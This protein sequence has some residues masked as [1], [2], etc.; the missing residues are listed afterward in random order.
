MYI[1]VIYWSGLILTWSNAINALQAQWW[2]T[3]KALAQPI[4]SRVISENNSEWITYT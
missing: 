1:I 3:E 2:R 4:S